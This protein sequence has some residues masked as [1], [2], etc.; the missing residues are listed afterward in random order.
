MRDA[1]GDLH[2]LMLAQERADAPT[3]QMPTQKAIDQLKRLWRVNPTFD[4]EY[5]YGFEA[6][7]DELA[8]WHQE[9][10]GRRASILRCS[11]LMASILEEL[12]HCWIDE[13]PPSSPLARRVLLSF[14]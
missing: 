13:R 1:T 2:P 7:R 10:I 11:P 8:A 6:V 14:R 9:E 3:A 12:V 5:A 4:V